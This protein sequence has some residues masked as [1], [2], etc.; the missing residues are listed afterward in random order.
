LSFG[1]ILT[2]R[3]PTLKKKVC[4]F[5]GGEGSPL[6]ANVYLPEVLDTWFE[7]VVKAH[8]RGQVVLDRYGDDFLIG[9]ELE[10][11]ARRIKAVLPKRFAK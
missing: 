10:E 8:C 1:S 2:R 3:S 4:N 5:V 7:T 11:D 9:C 6:L